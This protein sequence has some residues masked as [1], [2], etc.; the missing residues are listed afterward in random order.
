MQAAV[1]DLEALAKEGRE[2]NPSNSATV[3]NA[4]IIEILKGEAQF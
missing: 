4:A 3:T 2:D 1:A